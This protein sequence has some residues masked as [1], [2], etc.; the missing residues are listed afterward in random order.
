[1]NLVAN[2]KLQKIRSLIKPSRDFFH[3]LDNI[4][5]NITI[6][7]IT[8]KS[9]TSLI[10]LITSDKGLCGPYNNNI[11][12][13]TNQLITQL[14]DR[15]LR[16]N[17]IIIGSKGYDYFKYRK[18]DIYS[19][20]SIT[21][22]NALFRAKEISVNVIKKYNNLEILDAYFIY[23][24]YI[25]TLTQKVAI[26]NI[27]PISSHPQKYEYEHDKEFAVGFLPIYLSSKIYLALIESFV[28]EQ[29]S[30]VISMDTAANNANDLLEDLKIQYFRLRQ[31]KITQEI[32]E[33]ISG[34]HS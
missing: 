8:N 27:F 26:E 22:D 17:L 1:M 20:L 19:H 32:T 24:K 28:S 5:N 34:I 21:E 10:I 18:I 11:Y 31:A 12:K 23:T 29:A 25:S 30:R 9:N 13:S 15:G 33:I 16:S 14:K 6:E 2:A 7:H 3:E 4:K